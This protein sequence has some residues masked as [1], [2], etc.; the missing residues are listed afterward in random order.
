VEGLVVQVVVVLE[1]QVEQVEHLDPQEMLEVLE[2]QVLWRKPSPV[3][4]EMIT[5]SLVK[6]Q[7]PHS[8]VMDKWMVVIMLTQKQNAKHSTFVPMM[9]ME[10]LLNTVSCVLMEQCSNSSTLYATGGLMWIVLLRNSSI[11]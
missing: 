5:Q 11:Q 8:S 3:C 4:Q 6:Y 2:V 1:A 7:R 10:D 9:E